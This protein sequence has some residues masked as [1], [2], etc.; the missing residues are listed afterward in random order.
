LPELCDLRHLFTERYGSFLEN[1]ISLEVRTI[2][3]T[4]LSLNFIVYIL[5][6]STLHLYMLIQPFYSQFVQKLESKEFTNE[7]KL[8]VMQ[9]IAEE[10]LVRFDAKKL[11]LKLW[12]T[13]ETEYV[14]IK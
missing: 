6:S 8:H 4:L 1:F 3:F 7:K 13:S 9:S 14:S 12:P 5:W 11:E 2:L 10:L